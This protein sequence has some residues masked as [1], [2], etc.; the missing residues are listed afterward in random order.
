[1]KR[2]FRKYHRGLAIIICLP[3]AATVLTGMAATLTES[4]SLPLGLSH[5]LLLRIH[6]G[7]ILHLEGIYPLLNGLGVIGLI[8]TG[9]SQ[10]RLFTKK[11]GHSS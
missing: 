11:S 7:E 9:L 8:V 2:A 4:W 3:L 6:T 5:R 1:M 10:S